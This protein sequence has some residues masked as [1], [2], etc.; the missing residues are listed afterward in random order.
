MACLSKLIELTD[1]EK[2]EL[3][4]IIKK[5]THKSRKIIRA[6]ALLMISEGKR[7]EEVKATLNFDDN[8]YYKIKRQYFEG[9]LRAVLEE[10]PRSGQPRKVTALLE[11]Q[12]TSIF[13]SE[14][15]AG[16][17]RWTLSLVNNKLVQLAYVD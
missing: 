14:C 16:S 11:A 13:C 17:A 7:R 9:G 10:K 1:L 12:I 4:S 5:G 15:P 3:H 2:A 6:W 8:R